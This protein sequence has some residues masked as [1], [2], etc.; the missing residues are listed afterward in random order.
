[1]SIPCF[2][3]IGQNLIT[4]S[5]LAGGEAG[6]CSLTG[7]SKIQ[8]V[9]NRKEQMGIGKAN[10]SLA[11]LLPLLLQLFL[12]CARNLPFRNLQVLMQLQ[13]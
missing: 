3:F 2:Y 1:M 4:W 5:L 6:K 12:L 13:M 10:S 7:I 9:I 8:A 11:R